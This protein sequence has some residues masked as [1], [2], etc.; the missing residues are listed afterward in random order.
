MPPPTAPAGDYWNSYKRDELSEELKLRNVASSGL[1]ED[2][3]ERLR[4]HDAAI[5]PATA[6]QVTYASRV[7]G[8]LGHIM[9]PR[10]YSNKQLMIKFI[11]KMKDE[12]SRL[13]QTAHYGEASKTSSG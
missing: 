4:V 10:V 7:A 13:G 2:L 6:T 12:E 5:G 1:K 11:D 8:R 9:H 3:K